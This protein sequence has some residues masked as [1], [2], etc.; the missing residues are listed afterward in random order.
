M[1]R[2]PCHRPDDFDDNGLLK[3]PVFFW[4]GLVMLA[5]TWWLAGLA[6][7]SEHGGYWFVQFY[8]DVTLQW[9]GLLTGL[10]ALVM[11]FCYPVRS[12]FPGLVR[13]VFLLMLATALTAVVCDGLALA[14]QAPE[15]QDV[16]GLL[17]CADVACLSMLLPDRR[18]RAVFFSDGL[19]IYVNK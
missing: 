13:V 3:A 18:L 8:P 4:V 10:P 11:L 7:V 17:L 2:E 19:C 6:I 5:R 15:E 9:P 1:M 12:Q 14:R 16:A